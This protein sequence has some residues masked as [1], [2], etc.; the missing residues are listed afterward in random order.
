MRNWVANYVS[1][2]NKDNTELFANNPIMYD[3]ANIARHE[4]YKKLYGDDYWVHISM[5]KLVHRAKIPFGNGLSNDK[6]PSK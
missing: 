6:M 1:I 2:F 5:H 3:A 4:A